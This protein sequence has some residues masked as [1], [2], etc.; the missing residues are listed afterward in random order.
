M[1]GEQDRVGA[2]D[3]L[4][5]RRRAAPGFPGQPL[6]LFLAAGVTERDVVSGPRQD[7]PEL[8]PHQSGTKYSDVHRSSLRLC[9][10]VSLM[11]SAFHLR[12]QRQELQTA[13]R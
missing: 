10:A 1:H 7:R 8:A 2:G 5:G 9:G 4:G 13:G 11:P 12:T 3:S 6:E